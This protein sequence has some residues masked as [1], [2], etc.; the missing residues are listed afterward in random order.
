MPS[1]AITTTPPD[2]PQLDANAAREF[3]SLENL[4]PGNLYFGFVPKVKVSGADVGVR[5]APGDRLL[6]TIETAKW[7]RN[8]LYFVADGGGATLNHVS[9]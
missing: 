4:G 5:M 1:T 6:M 3:L 7:L 8:A 2:V 9:R